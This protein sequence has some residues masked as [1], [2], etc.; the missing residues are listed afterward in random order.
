MYDLV[1]VDHIKLKCFFFTQ[2]I[3]VTGPNEVVERSSRTDEVV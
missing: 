1:E 3:P 2:C